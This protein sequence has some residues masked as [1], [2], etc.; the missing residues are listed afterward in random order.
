MIHVYFC[1]W[2]LGLGPAPLLSLGSR[3]ISGQ[4]W[5]KLERNLLWSYEMPD[6]RLSEEVMERMNIKKMIVA[7]REAMEEVSDYATKE[8]TFGLYWTQGLKPS[9]GG[10]VKRTAFV[11][12]V[13]IPFVLLVTAG[14]V[15][16]GK[17][18]E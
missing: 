14:V 11:Y 2:R 10:S 13:V 1:D 7:R 12:G 8:A 6:S 16:A 15:A 4:E 9:V 5:K 18:K 3:E 17:K